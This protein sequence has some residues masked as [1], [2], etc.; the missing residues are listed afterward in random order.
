MKILVI[1]ENSAKLNFIRNE[2]EWVDKDDINQNNKNSILTTNHQIDFR[3]ASLNIKGYKVDQVF[4]YGIIDN[5]VMDVIRYSVLN[6]SCVP[7]EY[8]IQWIKEV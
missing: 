4:I 3:S 6:Y 7:E 2:I 1:A 5:E 8:Q